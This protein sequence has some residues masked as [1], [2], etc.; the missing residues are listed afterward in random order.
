MTHWQWAE[1]TLTMPKDKRQGMGAQFGGEYL[2]H[3]SGWS[4]GGG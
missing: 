1:L 3:K 2:A 4:N